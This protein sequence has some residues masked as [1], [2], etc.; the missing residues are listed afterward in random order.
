MRISDWSSDVCSSDLNG[1]RRVRAASA[2][3][4]RNGGIER[5]I[6]D[7][8]IFHR[9]A[10]ARARRLGGAARRVGA[11]KDAGD[12]FAACRRKRVLELID[13]HP[14]AE[15]ELVGRLDLDFAEAGNPTRS[16]ERR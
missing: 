14:R 3:T 13:A 12:H 10:R 11:A 5:R 7:R 9:K 8:L 1:N 4:A 2:E 16:A 6:L 15:L